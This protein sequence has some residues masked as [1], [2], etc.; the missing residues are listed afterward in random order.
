MTYD[1]RK[2]DYGK[3]HIYVVE[4]DQPQCI[5]T[6]GSAP[7]L[8]GEW[9]VVSTSVAD[10]S[11]AVG[12][13]I[14]GAT[15]GAKGV[16]TAVSIGGTVTL[17]YRITNGIQF[18]S[19]SEQI[20]NDD[21]SGDITK[22]TTAPAQQT[23]D[24]DDKCYNTLGSCQDIPNYDDLNDTGSIDI[25]V[26][27][28]NGTFT[29]ISAGSFLTDGFQVN[30]IITTTGYINAG[31]NGT[32]RIAS[33]TATVITVDDITGLVTETGTSNER[34]TATNRIVYRFC[35]ERSPHP[36]NIDAIPS[37]GKPN[38]SPAKINVKGG[39]GVRSSVSMSFNDH[40]ASDIGVD[41]YLSD[42]SFNPLDRGTFWT[43]YRARNSNYENNNLRLYTGYLVDNEFDETNFDVRYYIVDKIEATKGRC[44]LTAKDP[45]KLAM[46]KKAQAPEVSGG[47]VDTAIVDASTTIVLKPSGI[48]SEYGS[49]GKVLIDKE[50]I[51]FGGRTGD[52]LNTLTRAQNNT[53]QA[54][55]SV[56]ATVQLCLEYS[57]E[58]VDAIV[59]DLLTTYAGVDPVF[60][61]SGAWSAEVTLNISGLLN[62]VI[63][64]PVD[65]NKLL[66]ELSESAPHYLWWDE[67]S[68]K[69][70]L[71]ALK[72][73]PSMSAVLNMDD[74][75]I[76]DSFSTTDKNDMR[77][78]T[79]VVNYGQ[80]NP[81]L[82]VDEF[83]NYEASYIRVD[84][85]SLKK[86]TTSQIMTV[87]SRWINTNA[88]AIAE[89]LGQLVGR[90][91]SDVPREIRFSL[92]PKDA[93]GEEGLWAGDT[94]AISHR[95][96]V[97]PTGLPEETIFQII[98]AAEKENKFDFM[99][100]E[101]RYGDLLTGETEGIENVIYYQADTENV[102]L[103]DDFTAV[104]GTPA[105]DD[106]CTIIVEAGVVISSTSTASPAMDTGTGWPAFTTGKILLQLES[107]AVICGKG[108]D[109]G[110]D[111]V[112]TNG[113]EA[114]NLQEDITLANSGIIGGG[115]GGGGGSSD[116][117][118]GDTGGGGGAGFGSK[119]TFN[120]DA[121]STL[122]RASEDGTATAGGQGAK[123]DRGA[124]D[125]IVG[126]KGGDL[127]QA[128][129]T[130]V[131]LNGT[132][133]GGGSAGKAIDLN[134]NTI[135][136]D[137]AGDIR[138]LV[139]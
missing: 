17:T 48:G 46:G 121:G 132:D 36:V 77:V 133:Y 134:G 106:V 13:N 84:S 64:K 20:T 112:G 139:S 85:Q 24:G 137:L 105:V 98:S 93:G 116:G 21:D 44:S 99:A 18:A 15:S 68:Q 104:W 86:Y 130:G 115:G 138:G 127:G 62:T 34:I 114:L 26:N 9:Q 129:Q 79:V 1:Q 108:G 16:L 76:A 122:D 31:N 33:V 65:V 90:R 53:V 35:Q 27:A 123:I 6:Y 94:R 97:D 128:G 72:A 81:T 71:T 7:C 83:S 95:D 118:I 19:G 75:I 43:K 91:F 58:T 37:L 45:L 22:N 54:D 61:P 51:S 119:G 101:F 92:D 55:H 29:R 60:I 107:G 88:K 135:T 70:Q 125:F 52:T 8:A 2:R 38:I 111:A 69:I 100:L 110:E 42:R 14:T 87:N 50:I 3:E 4:I 102:N 67:R 120:V 5:L 113:G 32:F 10:N 56:D 73:P 78:S 136:Y 12:D 82:K 66:M 126:G 11:F 131:A 57:G 28:P 109:G 49:S 103:Y 117:N 59:E 41:P 30:D 40:T 23:I 124:L 39:L 63:V 47:A 96:M 25:D 89:K 74:N 80:I